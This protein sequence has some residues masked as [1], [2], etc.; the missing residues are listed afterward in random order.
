MSVKQC[1]ENIARMPPPGNHYCPGSLCADS[2]PD[3]NRLCHDHRFPPDEPIAFYAPDSGKCYCCCGAAAAAA[4]ATPVEVERGLYRRADTLDVGDR[5]LATDA[6]LDGWTA[7]TVTGLGGIGPG[8]PDGF[9]LLG[10][11]RMEGGEVRMLIAP[12]DHLFLNAEPGGAALV[13]FARLR[14]GDRV[15]AA[16]GG[17]ASV[18]LTAYI[19]FSGGVRQVALGPWE[20]GDPL[21]GHLVNTNGLVTADLSVQLAWYAGT[22]PDAL[23]AGD[24]ALPAVGSAE[25]HAAYDTAAYTAF[26]SDPARWPPLCRPLADGLPGAGPPAR[27]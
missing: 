1:L 25:F 24:A 7:H 27:A 19:R 17:S 6:S 22:L 3:I 26:V 15:R 9:I 13:P 23:V 20:P 8:A 18:V 10:H 2:Q 16:D 4:V 14:P 11:F 5:V 21:D 12:A